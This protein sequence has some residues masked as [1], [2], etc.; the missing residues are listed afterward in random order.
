MSVGQ[1]HAAGL[2]QAAYMLYCV[3]SYI[4]HKSVCGSGP[5][6]VLNYRI[7]TSTTFFSICP[8]T[9]SPPAG[10]PLPL[11]DSS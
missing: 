9:S 4:R 1:P 7:P 8:V 11:K 2:L 5:R 3:Y 10:N 6:M